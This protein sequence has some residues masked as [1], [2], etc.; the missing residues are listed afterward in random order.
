MSIK[1]RQAAGMDHA[2]NSDDAG[3]FWEQRYGST[4]RVWSGRVNAHL[5]EVAADL[6]AGRALDLGCGEG[7]DALWLAERG[8]RVLAVDVSATALQRAAEVAAQRNLAERIDFQ[9]HDL[10]ETFPDG[11]FD[12]VSAQ[13]LHSPARL[14]RDAVL[15]QAA[16]HVAPGGVLLIVD[17]AAAPP[18]SEHHSHEFP[19]VE[20]VL[21][22]LRLDGGWTRLR[23]DKVERETLGPDDRA[24]T[25]SDNV[26]VLRRAE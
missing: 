15:R 25:V 13:Y 14:D 11:T 26:M 19:G 17:H 21:A 10:N 20:E 2:D 4:G 1:C 5:A 24:A 8:W 3:Q 7:A 16:N 23:A 9:C 6:P 18:W 12:L 22:S